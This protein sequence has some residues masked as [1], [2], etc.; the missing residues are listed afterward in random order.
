MITIRGALTRLCPV[1]RFAGA[2]L[3]L[4][5]TAGW[6]GAVAAQDLDLR[7]EYRTVT[8][9][10]DGVT[11]STEYVERFTRRADRIWAEKVMPAVVAGTQVTP[12]AAPGLTSRPWRTCLSTTDPA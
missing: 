5:C 8:V 6:A 3:A 2:W 11:R 12:P 1:V 7:L 9:G 4:A 10:L